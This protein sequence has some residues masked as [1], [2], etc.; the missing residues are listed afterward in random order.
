MSRFINP[1]GKLF[2]HIDRLADLKAGF[3][4]P[5]VNVEVDLA[6]R[7]NLGCDFCHFAFTHTR[8]PLAGKRAKPDGAIPGGDRMA[9]ELAFKI[10][11]EFV[12]YGVRSV[13]WTGGGEPTI[14]PDFDQIISYAYAAGLKQGIYTNG[15]LIPEDRAKLMKRALDWVYVSLDAADADMYRQLKG[16]DKFDDAVKGI[17]RLAQADGDAT[18]GVGFLICRENAGQ[19]GGARY[20][21]S[22]RGADYVQYRPIIL[23]DQADQSKR[24]DDTAWMDDAIAELERFAG[25]EDIEVDLERFRMYRDWDG[26]PYDRCFWTGLQ[27]VVTPN[28]KV[29]T[30]VNKREYAGCELGDLSE[31]S[32]AAVWERGGGPRRVDG[33]CR[34]M[35]R[36]HIAN[37][38]LNDVFAE[39]PHEAFV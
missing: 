17:E 10:I 2:A 19:I 37:L 22:S 16:V 8:G 11:D 29:W 33:Q 1:T 39:R 4:P 15:T 27:S 13:T 9:A 32:F 12:E 6:N 34:V 31:E 18:V 28:G 26:H 24:T 3:T 36:G 38:S 14:H 7:C 5:P 25:Q 20:I 21:A 35:C 23:F 30:C